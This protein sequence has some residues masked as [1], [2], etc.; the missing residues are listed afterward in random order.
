MWANT[1]FRQVIGR[2]WR[3]PQALQVIAYRLI[4]LGTADETLL[5]IAENK[6]TLFNA[7]NS[8]DKGTIKGEPDDAIEILI[9]SKTFATQ[10]SLKV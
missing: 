1:D 4:A 2:L 5:D 8:H 10:G 6:E 9:F 7:F 3:P